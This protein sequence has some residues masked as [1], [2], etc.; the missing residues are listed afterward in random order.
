[1]EFTEREK[2]ILVDVLEA[3]LETL[4]D[5]INDGDAELQEE[6]AT[7]NRLLYKLKQED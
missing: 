6:R 7:V 2:E 4:D 1:M 5:R 3:H